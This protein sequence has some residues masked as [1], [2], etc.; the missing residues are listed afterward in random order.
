VRIRVERSGGFAGLPMIKEVD[1]KDIP[2][3]LVSAVR[4]I[5][6]N[7]NSSL[8]SSKPIPRGAADHY[9]YKISIQD[10]ANQDVIECNQY[11]VQDE[12]KPL[13]KYVERYSKT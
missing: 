1:G 12:L 10:G 3:N 5:M 11:D 9:S 2:Q 13:I 6:K 7:K 8:I 4:K